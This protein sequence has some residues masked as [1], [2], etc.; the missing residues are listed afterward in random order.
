MRCRLL[1][2][3]HIMSVLRPWLQGMRSP[4]WA[5]SFSPSVSSFLSSCS[6][7]TS[8]A[9]L[10]GPAK[11]SGKKGSGKPKPPVTSASGEPPVYVK[12]TI[13]PLDANNSKA[14]QAK[15]NAERAA[16]N[17]RMHMLVVRWRGE[18]RLK[19]DADADAAAIAG[20]PTAAAF[21]VLAPSHAEQLKRAATALGERERLAEVVE[22]LAREK[23]QADVQLQMV[24]AAGQAYSG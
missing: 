15:Y 8:S 24:S 14:A 22:T 7:W 19:E 3:A 17:R 12:R 6:I 4:L 2:L 16:W 20:V 18:Q 5:T 11:K 10:A 1:V 21:G 9:A 23:R 13:K